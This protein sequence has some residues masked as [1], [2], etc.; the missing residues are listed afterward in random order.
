M[1]VEIY[2]QDLVID[3]NE[4]SYLVDMPEYQ[5]GPIPLTINVTDESD[6][7]GIPGASIWFFYENG[8]VAHGVSDEDGTIAMINLS[9]GIASVVT[10]KRGYEVSRIDGF[11][12]GFETDPELN[13]VMSPLPESAISAIV[14]TVVDEN[15]LPL[16]DAYVGVYPEM[17]EPSIFAVADAEVLTADGEYTIDNLPAGA[18]EVLCTKSGYLPKTMTI[19]VSDTGPLLLDFKLTSEE[20]AWQMSKLP[21]SVE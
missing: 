17:T 14:G 18:Y 3:E 12:I 8:S 20:D 5:Q 1:G 16:D 11:E 9:E 10:V 7:S 13:V 21:Q 19:F 15:D 6:D 2:S 4:M